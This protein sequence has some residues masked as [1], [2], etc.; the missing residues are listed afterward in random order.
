VD[1]Q[2]GVC[3]KLAYRRVGKVIKLKSAPVPVAADGLSNT[4]ERLLILRCLVLGG[5]TNGLSEHGL[6]AISAGNTVG[7][8]GAS[9]TPSAVVGPAVIAG[10]L[11]CAFR[12]EASLLVKRNG[13]R[14]V[15][16]AEDISTAAAVMTTVENGEGTSACG[17]LALCSAVIR[18]PV[19]PCWGTS[20]SSLCLVPLVGDDAGNAAFTPRA[21]RSGV[22]LVGAHRRR[23]KTGRSDKLETV[24]GHVH[25]TVCAAGRG[26]RCLSRT[27]Q[28]SGAQDGRDVEGL[29]RLADLLGVHVCGAVGRRDIV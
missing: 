8:R 14:A 10:T 24:P 5:N 27:R 2:V 13:M 17:R 25:A 26:Q 9:S 3:V 20:N 28:L 6:I 4:T 12:V 29:L 15:T 1:A 16:A 22:I 11:K 21:E 23:R 18:L 19:V 7:A